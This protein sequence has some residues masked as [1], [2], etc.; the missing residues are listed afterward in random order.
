MLNINIDWLEKKELITEKKVLLNE[1]D[2]ST[3][4]FLNKY[5]VDSYLVFLKKGNVFEL[6]KVSGVD[7]DLAYSVKLDNNSIVYSML[8]DNSGLVSQKDILESC[9]ES[10][11]FHKEGA[12]LLREEIEYWESLGLANFYPVRDKIHGFMGFVAFSSS[13]SKTINKKK[14]GK[15]KAFI[16]DSVRYK[17][18]GAATRIKDR[19]IVVY[20][21]FHQLLVDLLKSNNESARDAVFF[22]FKEIFNARSAIMYVAEGKYF[23]PF[24]YKNISFIAPLNKTD[25]SSIKKIQKMKISKDGLLSKE[26]ESGEVIICKVTRNLIMAFK[27]DKCCD[28]LDE[29]MLA[30]SISILEKHLNG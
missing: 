27:A 16:Q 3:S 29:G 9:K 17:Y 22:Y 24:R 4:Q 13:D 15:F 25:F 19:E 1:Q 30:S 10:L 11:L 26:F 12:V 7:S 14:L 23:V 8:K 21:K 18:E 20:K 28:E 6:S 2:I 5:T